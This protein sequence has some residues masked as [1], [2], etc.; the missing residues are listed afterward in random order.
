MGLFCQFQFAWN[1]PNKHSESFR[2]KFSCLF[3]YQ[4][5]A[6]KQL[7]VYG[8]TDSAGS[9]GYFTVFTNGANP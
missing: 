4:S 6:Q 1:P 9:P 7:C 8:H 2:K 5:A 3:T